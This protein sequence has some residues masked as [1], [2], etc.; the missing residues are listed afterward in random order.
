MKPLTDW[1]S[2][3]GIA[4]RSA[5]GEQLRRGLRGKL[6]RRVFRRSSAGLRK[7]SL[8]IRSRSPTGSDARCLH[9]SGR[10]RNV[11]A[12]GRRR[13]AGAAAFASTST[14]D[15]AAVDPRVRAVCVRISSVVNA[16]RRI[17]LPKA[18][19]AEA[20]LGPSTSVRPR[21]SL[22][23]RGAPEP[24]V[25]RPSALWIT[26]MSEPVARMH[27]EALADGW[28]SSRERTPTIAEGWNLSDQRTSA[29][30]LR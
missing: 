27:S 6:G 9:S 18:D 28:K 11:Q 12:R 17:G 21:F 4:P 23:A 1:R 10:A 8:E 5:P 19:G 26:G 2:A 24:S 7:S 20:P 16:T 3:C 30:P 13:F 29:P 22:N 25:I 14:D 15:A